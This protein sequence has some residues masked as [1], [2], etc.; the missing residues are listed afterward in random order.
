MPP[1]SQNLVNTD[2]SLINVIN[3]CDI[4]IRRLIKMSKKISSF[5]SLCQRD[6][7]ALLKGGCT[8]LMILRSVTTY[9]AENNS[10][11]VSCARAGRGEGVRGIL[12]VGGGNDAVGISAAG[13]VSS[14]WKEE[15]FM[16]D[17]K[18]FG[19]HILRLVSMLRLN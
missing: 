7:I 19:Y 9:D 13:D 16:L 8:E 18:P 6:Q 15:S 5:R 1:L 11:N 4:A 14:S 17:D 12:C 2:P 10:W 3:L